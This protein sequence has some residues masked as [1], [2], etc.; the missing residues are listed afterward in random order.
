MTTFTNNRSNKIGSY[1][2]LLSLDPFV[3]DAL[4]E[5]SNSTK[6]LFDEIRNSRFSTVF[7]AGDS[8]FIEFRH[9]FT[10]KKSSSGSTININTFDPGL[11]FLN[12]LFFEFTQKSLRNIT[13]RK[14]S[15]EKQMREYFSEFNKLSSEILTAEEY[16]EERAQ[17]LQDVLKSGGLQKIAGV[18]QKMSEPRWAKLKSHAQEGL[19]E[20]KN[21]LKEKQD[22]QAPIIEEIQKVI[23]K[24]TMPK[25]YVMYGIGNDLKDWAGPFETYLG[26]IKHKNNGKQETVEYELVV[27]YLSNQFSVDVNKIG[28]KSNLF[29][30][31]Q[32][33]VLVFNNQS[34]NSTHKDKNDFATKSY[35]FH[36]VIVKLLSNY[37]FKI[38]IKNHIIFLPYLDLMLAGV[39]ERCVVESLPELGLAAGALYDPDD[40]MAALQSPALAKTGAA[41]WS[42]YN[43]VLTGAPGSE[44]LSL[45]STV[46][47]SL[48]DSDIVTLLDT[49][50]PGKLND[51]N[52][53]RGQWVSRGVAPPDGGPAISSPTAAQLFS[54]LY[55]NLGDKA[56]KQTIH[57]FIDTVFF[58]I[59][60]TIG[61]KGATAEPSSDEGLPVLL[62]T[63]Q[64][65]YGTKIKAP[66]GSN[67]TLLGASTVR[68]P[69][70]WVDVTMLDPFKEGTPPKGS[71]ASTDPYSGNVPGA[72]TAEKILS[73][74]LGPKYG[75]VEDAEEFSWQDPLKEMVR[76]LNA[77]SANQTITY[78]DYFVGDI[79]TKELLIETFGGGTFAGYTTQYMNS[80]SIKNKPVDDDP[81]FIFGDREL[82]R[83]FLYGGLFPLKDNCPWLFDGT[84]QLIEFAGAPVGI[85]NT[86]GSIQDPCWNRLKVSIDY[87]LSNNPNNYFE[88]TYK[89]LH[90]TPGYNLGY[91]LDILDSPDKLPMLLPDEFS[92]DPAKEAVVEEDRKKL[93]KYIYETAF[94][95]FL[96]NTAN[97]NV[98]GY[99]FDTNKF[100]YSQLFGSIREVY[101]TVAK[102]Y[103]SA[104]NPI[105]EPGMTVEEVQEKMVEVLDLMA[106]KSAGLGS[107]LT[108][109]FGI[110]RKVNI[111]EMADL[112]A[113]LILLETTGISTKIRKGKGSS[114]VA[115]AQ[116]FMNIMSQTYEGTIKTLP[117]FHLSKHS[118]LLQ[119]CLVMLKPVRRIKPGGN[120]F[121]DDNPITDFLSGIYR[122]IGFTHRIT[123]KEAY[124]EFNLF[125]DITAELTNAED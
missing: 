100:I 84:D 93:R 69:D 17:N 92:L 71:K 63:Q 109:T 86:K 38:G 8:N 116:L 30:T 56:R 106:S 29:S 107:R 76:S 103:Y 26:D 37:L 97:A 20:A 52:F 21:R 22:E 44:R 65:T 79:K 40:P 125:K 55:Q 110:S 105:L 42:N 95:M 78:E 49:L 13:E 89:A 23:G 24:R 60:K 90:H 66:L 5:R 73:I 111:D 74:Q 39:I 41:A 113:D 101:S 58:K 54:N 50:V 108:P 96:A 81:Y 82:I 51:A 115:F 18:W 6:F 104:D 3:V 85:L 102:R 46:A 98:L 80:L 99:S 117:M 68:D 121:E 16:V 87:V 75:E 88:R 83:L 14:D 27:D 35:T 77:I 59:F 122:M 118:D 45:V 94:P 9:D 119:Q 7:N 61:L 64:R 43:S 120:T 72:I 31:D 67:L 33:P 123:A 53:T 32:I 36:D 124:S 57:K 91:Y 12:D 19:S 48:F 47:K 4:K 114:I 1:Q 70:W 15:E 112:L 10:N 62:N 28:T 11:K 25:V 34:K 2:I